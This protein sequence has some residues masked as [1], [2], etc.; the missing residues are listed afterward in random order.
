LNHL[1]LRAKLPMLGGGWRLVEVDTFSSQREV[2]AGRTLM[3]DVILEGKAWPFES[4]FETEESFRGYFLS[5]AAFVVRSVREGHDG[6]GN[7]S[8]LGCF[9]I[10]PNFPGRCSHICNGGFIVEPNLRGS[11]VGTLMGACF[12]RFSK[13]LGYKAAYFNLVFESNQVSVRLWE[14][15]GFD[16]VAV[17]PKAARLEGMPID[18]ATGEPKLDTAFGYYYDL[19]KLPTAYDP[20]C[21]N[22][23][24]I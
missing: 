21:E 24:A 12:L 6:N 13:D 3:N 5:H 22:G 18:P 4:I 7:A 11:G 9:Y 15:L 2:E 8:V 16:R 10:K 14:K 20:I 17:I 23:F 19:D 1:P